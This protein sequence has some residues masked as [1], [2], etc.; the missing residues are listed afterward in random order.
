MHKVP[1]ASADDA[2]RAPGP[3]ADW[4]RRRLG[5]DAE[6]CSFEARTSTPER[7]GLGV[8]NGFDWEPR[9]GPMLCSRSTSFCLNKFVDLG[10]SLN[11][12]GH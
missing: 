7:L 4:F 10:L 2:I 11:V 12:F 6:S 9:S 5:S 3:V 8:E 1:N